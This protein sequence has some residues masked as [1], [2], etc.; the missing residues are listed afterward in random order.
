METTGIGEAELRDALKKLAVASDLRFGQV[1][2]LAALVALLPG[3]ETVQIEKVEEL[4]ERLTRGVPGGQNLKIP[5]V[6]IARNVITSAAEAKS[7]GTA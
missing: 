6:N 4:V 2:G 5:A 3:V 1:V 7:A